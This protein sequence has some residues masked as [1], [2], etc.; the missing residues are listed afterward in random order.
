MVFSHVPTRRVH[1]KML[2]SGVC[3]LVYFYIYTC[4]YVYQVHALLVLAQLYAHACIP[5]TLGVWARSAIFCPGIW[6]IATPPRTQDARNL[7]VWSISILHVI[8]SMVT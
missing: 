4:M 8:V 6:H 7:N 1:N 2:F 3:M 5:S